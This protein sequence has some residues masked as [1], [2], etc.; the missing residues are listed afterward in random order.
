MPINF[1]EFISHS[2]LKQ[3]YPNKWSIYLMEADYSFTT[4]ITS[5]SIV[6]LH[7]KRPHFSF[8]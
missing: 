3:K 2:T 8:A 7:L 4:Q 5:L 1:T 6:H